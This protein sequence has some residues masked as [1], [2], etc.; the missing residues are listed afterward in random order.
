MSNDPPIIPQRFP[1]AGSSSDDQVL[2]KEVRSAQIGLSEN[3]IRDLHKFVLGHKRVIKVTK[4]GRVSV[5]ASGSV[6]VRS[7]RV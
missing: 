3:E 5:H 1:T 4:G 2:A 7:H 6:F